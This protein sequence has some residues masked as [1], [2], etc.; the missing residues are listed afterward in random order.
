ML[1]AQKP[2]GENLARGKLALLLRRRRQKLALSRKAAAVLMGTSEKTLQRW[3]SGLT[4]FPSAFPK[5]IE[6][7]GSEP[8]SAPTTLAEH[9][10]VARYRIGL[11]IEDAAVQLGVDPSTLWWW[12]NGR[13]PHRLADRARIAAFIGGWS[14][15]SA[16][17]TSEPSD[18]DPPDQFDIGAMMK[19]RRTA[20]ALTQQAAA[21]LLG[22]N[23]WTVINWEN[24]YNAPS[25][26]L[27]P[28]LIRFLGCEPWP[29]PTSLGERLRAER[30]RRGLAR[31]QIA[32]LLQVDDSSIAA[33]EAGRGPYHGLAK[34]KV[35]AFLN[36]DPRPRRT[37]KRRMKI[38]V[39]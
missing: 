4:P 10:R 35:E 19:A 26:R 15:A 9:I 37:P 38:G 39:L 32:A 27:Y 12:E 33:W 17:V 36:G 28:N 2:D 16:D 3:E 30:L 14:E 24:G 29:E 8:W 22:V 6:F 5:I 34:A 25:D 11:R 23:E 13:R 18:G 7:L 31:T 20:L 21:S 1:R